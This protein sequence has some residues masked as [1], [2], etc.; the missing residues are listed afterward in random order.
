MFRELQRVSNVVG[1]DAGG[2]SVAGVV[3]ALD[4]LLQCIELQNALH[5]AEDLIKVVCRYLYL[6]FII[7]Y[8]SLKSFIIYLFG[9]VS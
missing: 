6:P 2:E 3:G 4:H 5:R 9:S 8:F 1:E 7:I